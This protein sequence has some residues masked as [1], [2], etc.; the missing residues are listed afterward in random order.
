MT[1]KVAASKKEHVRTPAGT[2]PEPTPV[3][4]T[5]PERHGTSRTYFWKLGPETLTG[6]RQNLPA[7]PL[8][9]SPEPAPNLHQSS[10]EKEV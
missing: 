5:N 1:I 10:W 7:E 9:T 8:G 3:P 6:T 4:G 2:S